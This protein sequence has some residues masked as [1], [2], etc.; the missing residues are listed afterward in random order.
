MFCKD[1]SEVLSWA[2]PVVLFT[3]ELFEGGWQENLSVV[4]EGDDS[5]I[6]SL[7]DS[8]HEVV[9]FGFFVAGP[10]REGGKRL[11]FKFTVDLWLTF[12]L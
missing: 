11:V 2:K 5:T 10:L 7:L 9:V 8:G 3:H 4:C 1:F 12:Q 6:F